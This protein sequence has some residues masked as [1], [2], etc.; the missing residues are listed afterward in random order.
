[1]GKEKDACPYL[2][3]PSGEGSEG[4]DLE[5]EKTERNKTPICYSWRMRNIP[6]LPFA[7]HLLREGLWRDL[8]KLIQMDGAGKKG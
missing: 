7:S 6:T 8:D 5:E 4:L 2:T 1:M 3:I